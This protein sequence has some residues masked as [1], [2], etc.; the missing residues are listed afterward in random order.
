MKKTFFYLFALFQLAVPQIA[1]GAGTDPRLVVKNKLGGA[2]SSDNLPEL[3]V[4]LG[5]AIRVGLGFVGVAAL[6]MFVWAGWKYLASA[7]SPEKAKEAVE[8]LKWAGI[9]LV[10]I[11]ASYILLSSIFG[12]FSPA[13][14]K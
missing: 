9:G 11:F 4:V 10:V 1:R 14:L 13:T 6:I 8:T 12:V 7:G 2:V 5:K 3:S